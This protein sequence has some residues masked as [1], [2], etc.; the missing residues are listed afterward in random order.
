[1]RTHAGCT[2][3]LGQHLELFLF[4][5]TAEAKV[6]DHD[7]RVFP[8]C[9]ENKVFWLEIYQSPRAWLD[10]GIAGGTEDVAYRGGRYRSRGCT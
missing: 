2:T 7:I 10:D 1:M 8:L 4:H 5:D 9:A 6:R 3:Y